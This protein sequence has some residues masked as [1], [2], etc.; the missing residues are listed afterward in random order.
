MPRLKTLLT[1]EEQWERTVRYIYLLRTD[2]QRLLHLR[3]HRERQE[4][5]DA[6]RFTALVGWR[7]C[8]RQIYKSTLVC[9]KNLDLSAVFS[10]K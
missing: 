9:A 5:R 2:R 7:S 6:S 1:P 4:N 10:H 8:D 3:T